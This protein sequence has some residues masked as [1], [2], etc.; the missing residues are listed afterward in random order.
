[1]RYPDWDLIVDQASLDDED[2][3]GQESKSQGPFI[4]AAKALP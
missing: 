2:Q 4:K 1:V 3:D